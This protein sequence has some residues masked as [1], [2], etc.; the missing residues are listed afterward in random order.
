MYQY[1]RIHHTA[2]FQ[3]EDHRLSADQQPLFTPGLRN[4]F[5][6]NALCGGMT[7]LGPDRYYQELIANN[8]ILKA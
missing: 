2:M 5:H 8:L 1:S 4:S 7:T 3:K 6:D